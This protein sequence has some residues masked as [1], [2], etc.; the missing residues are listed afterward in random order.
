LWVK[1]NRPEVLNAINPAMV[2]AL[3]AALDLAESR[4]DVRAVVLTGAGRAF[5]A[6][7]DIRYLSENRQGSVAVRDFLRSIPM[8]MERLE[9]FPCPVVAAVN[10]VAAGGGLELVLCCDLVLAA[11]SAKLGDAH[12][13]YGL[14][15]GGGG[16]VRLPRKI[17]VTRA[18]HLLFTGA[19]LTAA[20]M[21]K[22]GLVNE[23]VPDEALEDATMQ[24]VEVIARNSPLGIRRT[25]AVV[26][27]GMEQALPSALR[28]EALASEL[29]MASADAAEGI[30]AFA[31]K[32]KPRF[33]GR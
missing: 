26:N 7:A 19:L 15:P 22:A 21:V 27:D 31:E 10:G 23:A 8:L 2:S 17:G 33:V 18:K 14:M 9:R 4:E 13:N 32:R 28:L 6:G 3:H 12:A 11:R 25:K 30:S 16:A 29:H 5:C 1:L 20:E 24:L